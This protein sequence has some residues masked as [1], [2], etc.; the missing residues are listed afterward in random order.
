MQKYSLG[1]YKVERK[2]TSLI[3]LLKFKTNFNST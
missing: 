3:Y 2:E 1:E